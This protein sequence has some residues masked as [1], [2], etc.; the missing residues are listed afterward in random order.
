MSR[1]GRQIRPHVDTELQRARQ[2][3]HGVQSTYARLRGSVVLRIDRR[4]HHD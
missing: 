4:Q 3:S 2:A 1:F